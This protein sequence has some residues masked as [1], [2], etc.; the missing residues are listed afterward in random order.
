M[1]QPKWPTCAT[2]T[3]VP[4][5]RKRSPFTLVP[6]ETANSIISN[7]KDAV[8]LDPAPRILLDI[9]VCDTPLKFLYDP[10]SQNTIT[11]SSIYYN[12]Q[13]K[14]PLAPVNKV[15]IG[16]SGTHF[17]F[18]GAAHINLKFKRPDDTSYILE[19]GPVLVGPHITTCI[20][21]I[22][23]ELR[24]QCAAREHGEKCITFDPTDGQMVQMPHLEQKS[25]GRSAYKL[26]F[27]HEFKCFI[28]ISNN[29]KTIE[30]RGPPGPS[31]LLF[32]SCLSW[33]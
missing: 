19:Y 16:I 9:T 15:G 4:I 33:Q 6:S 31:V 28:A 23:S 27:K 8:N 20:F 21:G 3:T 32:S 17:Q 25:D 29:E 10:G 18:D 22:Y 13:H 12:I 2:I 14:P 30:T 11:S 24:F 26:Y 7:P 5:V 1:S